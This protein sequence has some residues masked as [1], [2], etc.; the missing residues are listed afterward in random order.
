MNR[1]TVGLLSVMLSLMV[2]FVWIDRQLYAAHKN[3]EKKN[4]LKS[5]KRIQDDGQEN[6]IVDDVDEKDDE[7]EIAIDEFDIQQKQK[8]V[9]S[10]VERG[11]EFCA[12]NPMTKIC[13]AFTHT[14][15]FIEGELYLFLLDTKGVVYA[16]G[17]REDLLWKNLWNYHDSFGALA[18]QSMIK[19][20]QTGTHWLTYEWAGAAKVSF[21]QQV[22]IDD[23]D[24]VLGCGYYP[25]SKKYAAIGL[26]KGAV[27]LFNQDVAEGRSI[28]AA[29]ST[30]GYSLSER[31][32]FGD[33]YL[34]ALDFDGFIRAQGEEPGLIGLNALD[35]T[36]V[37]G[38]PINKEI[39]AKLK[40]KEE[41]EGIWIEYTSKGA[42]KYTY[43][44]KVKDKKGKYYFIACG[45][46]PEI[47]RDKTVDLVRRGY[48]YM[49][50]S[51]VSVAAK[52]FTDKAV[53]TYRLGDL[54]LF[55]YDMKGKCIAHG[56]NPALVG[57]NRFD[58]K[59]QDG[60]YYIR[61]MIDQAKVGGGWVDS[62]LKNSF[63]STYV[64]KIDMGVDTYVIGAGMFPVAKPEMMTLLVKSAVGYLQTHSD[65]EAFEKFIAR[66]GE[67]I[68]GDLAVFAFDLD[69]YCYA[70]GDDHEL[71][72]K[73][74][75]GWKDDEGKLFVKQMIEQVLQGAGHFVYKF[76]KK[77]RVAYIEQVEKGDKKY[78]LGSGFYK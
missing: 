55:V 67:F 14:K 63:E 30:M 48:Q 69:G 77:M 12:R 39:I 22:K 71:I 72:W 73:N 15:E 1:R 68:R 54:Y 75:L 70:W 47:D 28:D 60:V 33:L 27:S 29:F 6:V 42:L 35:R 8:E 5:H 38:K 41:G 53:G 7:E 25:H 2:G 11:V 76:N 51:G 21:V 4:M 66:K 56:G 31:F 50:A 64:E 78:L 58:E 57:A 44:E 18:I 52:D 65:E 32:I 16:H 19:A 61:E 37:K 40:Q 17:A 9:R 46:Y 34:Y 74:L 43:A 59:D 49:K 23:K 20:A 26:V 45:Y 62:K 36:D 24:Y 3:N 10:L 13:H